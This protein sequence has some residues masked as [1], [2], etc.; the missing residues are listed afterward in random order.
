MNDHL[1]D[2]NDHLKLCKKIKNDLVDNF[3]KRYNYNICKNYVDFNE[4]N[5]TIN[6]I[7]IINNRIYDHLTNCTNGCNKIEIWFKDNS[8]KDNNFEDYIYIDGLYII[9]K[10]EEFKFFINNLKN[11]KYFDNCKLKPSIYIMYNDV[12]SENPNLEK[13]NNCKVYYH[14]VYYILY[15]KW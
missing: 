13:Y 15:I 10:N 3:K 12:S 2:I 11:D 8:P 9:K 14:D 5:N 6:M 1:N 7:N 4:L